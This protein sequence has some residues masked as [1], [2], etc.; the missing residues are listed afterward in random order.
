MQI[1]A[2]ELSYRPASKRVQTPVAWAPG[3]C[4]LSVGAEAMKAA[5][6]ASEVGRLGCR[7]LLGV[8]WT[9]QCEELGGRGDRGDAL[10]T[11]VPLLF[12]SASTKG[13]DGGRVKPCP[14]RR[15]GVGRRLL[16]RQL[17]LSAGRD[18]DAA[19]PSD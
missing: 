13:G 3:R 15:L 6:Q 7:S 18:S 12:G 1:Q 4:L 10:L 11:C 8:N 19:T 9:Q 17:S 2:Q 14:E 16:G 5:A